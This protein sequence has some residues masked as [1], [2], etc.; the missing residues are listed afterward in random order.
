MYTNLLSEKK[1][2]TLWHLWHSVYVWQTTGWHCCGRGKGIGCCV[3]KEGKAVRAISGPEFSLLRFVLGDWSTLVGSRRGRP[4]WRKE[5]DSLA[6]LCDPGW[7]S[8]HFSRKLAVASWSYSCSSK[9][10]SGP[11]PVQHSEFHSNP[12]LLNPARAVPV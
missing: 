3:G 7:G 8:K 6:V 4:S 12:P 1:C 9:G 5:K 11:S 10:G 2:A